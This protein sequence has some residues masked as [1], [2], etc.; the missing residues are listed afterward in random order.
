MDPFLNQM[1]DVEV[2]LI[3]EPAMY[4]FEL[5]LNVPMFQEECLYDGAL[6]C[7]WKLVFN[8]K[9]IHYVRH[10]TG[11]I[12]INQVQDYNTYNMTNNNIK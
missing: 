2:V 6:G 3:Y 5:H 11:K 9:L 8:H 4:C 12:V 10:D 1:V 7:I